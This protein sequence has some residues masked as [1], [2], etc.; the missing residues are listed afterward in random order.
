MSAPDSMNMPDIKCGFLRAYFI[1][2]IADSINMRAIKSPAGSESEFTPQPL[3]LVDV[4]SP[5]YI[6]FV[7][8][9]MVANLKSIS[10][11]LGEFAVQVK[12][13]DYGTVSIRLSQSYSGNWQ[14]F[15]AGSRKL[16]VSPEIMKAVQKILEEVVPAL[17]AALLK[18]H[19]TAQQRDLLED[20]YVAEVESFVS[21]I[22]ASELLR[23]KRLALAHLVSLEDKPLSFLQI[24]ES[25]KECFAYCEHELAV[26]T[27]DQAFIYDDRTGA[28]TVNAIIEFANTQLAELRVYDKR[29]DRHLDEIYKGKSESVRTGF[30]QSFTSNRLLAEKQ[31][32]RLR[33]LLV[34]VR[35]LS[36]RATNAIKIIG[37]AYY[38]RLYG[39]I[40]TRLGLKQW[41]EQVETKLDSVGEVYRY[42]NDQAELARS[43][44]LEMI[45]IF[46]IAL[47]VIIGVFFRH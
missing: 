5:A 4:P 17:D 15:L 2:D 10:S 37:C 26:L 40:S 36:D 42:T 20:Y 18:P 7:V 9:P 30:L 14:D 35:E 13:Y 3:Q 8:P 39:G 24:E 29:L 25:L 19:P 1:Y 41:Q 11:S 31:A 34:D 32:E 23:D 28:D 22:T 47:E 33:L 43:E 6:Q 45:V 27:W 44:F 21:E 16:R 38:A 12:I 46:L